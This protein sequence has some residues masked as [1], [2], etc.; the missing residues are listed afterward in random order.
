MR[1]FYNSFVFH[2]F[3]PIFIIID[4][5]FYR[6]SGPGLVTLLKH[7]LKVQ[8]HCGNLLMF[9]SDARNPHG[10]LPIQSGVRYA[11][12]TWFSDT[13]S[14]PKRRAA[15]DTHP[16]GPGNNTITKWMEPMFKRMES[17]CQDWGDGMSFPAPSGL[18]EMGPVTPDTCAEWLA[19]QRYIAHRIK[20]EWEAQDDLENRFN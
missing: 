5:F 8:P 18:L 1:V 12:P 9:T 20:D 2:D 16:K 10:T 19:H 6:Y 17:E 11:L 3:H 14:M 13:S 4:M 7:T 15:I